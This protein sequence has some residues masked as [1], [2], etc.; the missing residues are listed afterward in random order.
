S[1]TTVRSP[2]SRSPG[3][4]DVGARHVSAALCVASLAV[5]AMTAATLARQPPAGSRSI[6]MVSDLHLGEGRDA[7]GAWHPY[8]DFRW[9]PEFLAF[10][11]VIDDEGRGSTDLILNGDTF[12]LLQSSRLT[13]GSIPDLG[14]SEGEA[15]ARVQRV[16]A[17]HDAEIKALGQ[18]ARSGSN[19]V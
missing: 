13:C 9:T 4:R 11:K 19:R 17:A 2:G 1:A 3:A 15:M 18:F 7:S 8:E 10:V 16:L 5:A 6:V 12:E 14:C